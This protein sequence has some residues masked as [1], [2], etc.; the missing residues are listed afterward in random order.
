MG[1]GFFVAQSKTRMQNA[2]QYIC[3]IFLLMASVFQQYI[4]TQ[5]TSYDLQEQIFNFWG[6]R[7]GGETMKPHFAIKHLEIKLAK[8]VYSSQKV[9]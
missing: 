2:L 1:K 3:A 4:V 7:G 6:G 5:I 8:S 9:W